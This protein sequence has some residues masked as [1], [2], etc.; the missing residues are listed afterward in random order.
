MSL[1][2]AAAL[3]ITH[4]RLGASRLFDDLSR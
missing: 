3:V 2:A 1:F 4:Y